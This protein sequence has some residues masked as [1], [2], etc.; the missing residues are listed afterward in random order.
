MPCDPVGG[1]NIGL[2]RPQEQAGKGG[3]DVWV[4]FKRAPVAPTNLQKGPFGKETERLPYFATTSCVCE[5]IQ[6]RFKPIGKATGLINRPG[7][8]FF[9][10]DRRIP[11]N[12]ELKSGRK[13]PT[14]ISPEESVK[15][16]MYFLAIAL[17]GFGGI[18]QD[19]TPPESIG[20]LITKLGNP[21]PGE[22]DQA[23]ADLRK[24]RYDAF[25]ALH[26]AVET[27]PDLEIRGRATALLRDL[28][29]LE[30]SVK[31]TV[32]KFKHTPHGGDMGY[33]AKS[34]FAQI[35]GD[36]LVIRAT[37]P[38]SDEG[39][40]FTLRISIGLKDLKAGSI[41]EDRFWIAYSHGGE[42]GLKVMYITTWKGTIALEEKGTK[43][44]GRFDVSFSGGKT[45]YGFDE[46]T[47]KGSF[48]IPDVLTLLDAARQGVKFDVPPE[49]LEEVLLEQGLGSR[50]VVQNTKPK[51][52]GKL[53][54]T[55]GDKHGSTVILDRYG[56][57]LSQNLKR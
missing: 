13:R 26:E 38:S 15:L 2:W 49:T 46:Q 42:G 17:S 41:P 54:V 57:I 3:E 40:F 19:K 33:D 30:Y 4:R 11:K 14:G 1:E 53:E 24:L 31:L 28:S 18:A 5:R 32:S 22:R 29:S 21:S 56:N 48:E 51:E 55:L 6:V 43:L 45:A 35:R 50:G 52:G 27:N 7:T 23:T 39:S 16:F 25:S 10:R 20:K 47:L 44:E 12:W 8:T 9:G 34:T 37:G 36:R